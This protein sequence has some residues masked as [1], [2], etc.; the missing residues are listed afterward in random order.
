MLERNE[1]D[2]TGFQCKITGKRIGEDFYMYPAGY[3]CLPHAAA[4]PDVCPLTGE[5]LSPYPVN[6]RGTSLKND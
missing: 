5:L 1:E 4:S 3:V 6:N 2:Y